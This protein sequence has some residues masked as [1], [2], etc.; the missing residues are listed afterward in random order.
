MT[1]T[2]RL[3]RSS[4]DLSDTRNFLEILGLDDTAAYDVSVVPRF[5]SNFPVPRSI[6]LHFSSASP[7]FYS[8]SSWIGQVLRAVI[9]FEGNA[10]VSK[11]TEGRPGEM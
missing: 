5:Y 9:D 4:T 3:G 6:L 2:F 1:S 7:A 10:R 8:V 11:E